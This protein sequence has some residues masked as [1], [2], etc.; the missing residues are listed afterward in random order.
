MTVYFAA[1][2]ERCLMEDAVDAVEA[3]CTEAGRKGYVRLSLAYMRTD[4][5]RNMLSSFFAKEAR[6]PDDYLVMLD[7]DHKHPHNIIE[8]L[9]SHNVPV[10][11]CLAFRRGPPHYP[12]VWFYDTDG[13]FKHPK[14]WEQKLYRVAVVGSG[15]IAIKRRVFDELATK[16]IKS[17]WF[18]YTYPPDSDIDP[19]EEIHFNNLCRN[20]GIPLYCDFATQSPHLKV[21]YIQE[22]A[23]QEW[24]RLHPDGK[25][26]ETMDLSKVLMEKAPDVYYEPR[27]V[28]TLNLPQLRGEYIPIMELA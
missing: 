14:T 16:G 9:V 15:A 27:Q 4:I 22:H 21:G 25:D 19:S 26:P 8:R 3:V 23:W 20:H 7:Y 1:L 11:S 18:Q 6:S 28:G 2:K 12:C 10:V 24:L 17:R 13:L 5:T